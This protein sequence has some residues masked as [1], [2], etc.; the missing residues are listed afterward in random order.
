[1]AST[2]III[3]YIEIERGNH[4]L[5]HL[6]NVQKQTFFMKV[7]VEARLQ[8]WSIGI[9]LLIGPQ[10]AYLNQGLFYVC[11]VDTIYGSDLIRLQKG[12]LSTDGADTVIFIKPHRNPVINALDLGEVL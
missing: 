1:M 10:S 3:E 8:Y 2:D 12:Q 7:C 4:S 9:R 6:E 11:I 5:W